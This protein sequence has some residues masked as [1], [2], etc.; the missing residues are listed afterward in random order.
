MG[1]EE[2]GLYSSSNVRGFSP[3]DAGNVRIEGL[4]F[5]QVA[6]L[7]PR[8]QESS[9][10]RVGIAGQGYAFPAPTGVVDY[11]L[12]KP[13]DTVQ[14]TSLTNVS[15]HGA[16][17]LELDGAAPLM[18]DELSIGAGIGLNRNIFVAGGSNYEHNEGVTARWR[19]ASGFEIMPFWS[20]SDV[21]VGKSWPSYIPN[22]SFLPEP[23]PNGRFTG[24]DWALN[25]RFL[26]NYGSIV[27]AQLPAGLNLNIGLFR[28]EE[29]KIA[30][31]YTLLTN[32]DRQGVG[33]MM[34]YS[35]PPT[36]RRSTSGEIQ[37]ARTFSEGVRSH[38]AILSLRMRDRN[39]LYDGFDSVDL[40]PVAIN[41]RL[42]G[43]RPDFHYGPQTTD[44]VTQTTIGLAYEGL[45]RNVG[46][47]GLGIQKSRYN[48]K[49]VIPGQT[50]VIS[51]DDPWLFN[52]A[53]TG[54]VSDD[55]AVFGSFT[56]GLEESGVA[57][58]N[59]ANRNEA[60]PAIKTSQKD[61]GIRY[62]LYDGAKL[63]VALFDIQKPYFNLDASN[64]FGPLGDTQNR[65]V[66]FSLSG[67]IT[68]RLDIVAGAVFS[69]PEVTGKAVDL[70]VV[71]KRP[72]GI[73]GR[74]IDLHLEWRPP[75]FED[76]SLDMGVRHSGSVVSTRNN[77]V[78]IPD[79]T[80][81]DLGARYRFNLHNQ[82]ASLRLA[83]TN[84]FNI[85][86]YDL[87]GSGAY[88]LYGRSGRLL[89]TRLIVDL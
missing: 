45:W 5:D 70:G 21:Y 65:G 23:F 82:P 55:L 77:L 87:A 2:I 42:H 56:R 39:S 64:R 31:Y 10:I 24:P 27:R 50:A 75:G 51:K 60:L 18:G 40:G 32:L 66:E 54:F 15:N 38:R 33:D 11:L 48:K 17:T 76:G 1:N 28:S 85:R 34:I 72:V 30:Q 73:A 88:N 69:Q 3:T 63:V 78:S 41:Q 7:N 74:K 9:R 35:D 59:A 67:N 22:G 36:S 37:L 8:L 79:R 29:R 62:N 25:R 14:L 20:R 6:E 12:R 46:Q 81:V 57:P 53:L 52:A 89:E 44:H 49:T 58:Q 19:P 47:L 43:T 26:V 83:A 4:Y 80:M 84:I 71:G 86:S 16:V 13:G 61:L 68:P